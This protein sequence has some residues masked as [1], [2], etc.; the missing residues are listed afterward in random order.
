MNT[1]SQKAELFESFLDGKHDPD[2][3]IYGDI[4]ADEMRPWRNEDFEGYEVWDYFA[5]DYAGYLDYE[6]CIMAT[7]RYIS[8]KILRY[9]AAGDNAAAA[10]ARETMEAL[11]KLAAEGDKVQSGYLPK[12][13]GGL[14]K[15]SL[16]T[17]ISTDQY[18][19]AVFAMWRFI[20]AFPQSPLHQEVANEIVKI[21][22]YFVRNDFT[23]QGYSAVYSTIEERDDLEYPAFVSIHTFGLYLPLMQ[24]AYELTGD[25]KYEQQ[26]Q[27]LFKL[28]FEYDAEKEYVKHQNTCNL[29]NIGLYF[30]WK[31]G[32]H[33]E[34]LAAIMEK[35]WQLDSAMLSSDGLAY[36]QPDITDDHHIEPHYDMDSLDPAASL[37]NYRFMAWR[38]N[39]KTAHSCKTAHSGALLQRV[40]F[41]QRR[42]SDIRRILDHYQKPEDFRRYI[43]F[44]GKQLPPE[45]KYHGNTIPL[46][47][48]GAWLEAYY[49]NDV[50]HAIDGF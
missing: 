23:Y 38:S 33:R 25:K 41:D 6:D 34:K 26:L 10:D 47:F 49:L 35:Q 9:L 19:H 29:L 46:Q 43:D 18:E 48:V 40:R 8:V 15:A 3:L 27:R 21:A 1:L 36:A 50:I 45:Y 5:D 11:L 13:H 44:D 31:R 12:P 32:L 30:C 28:L 2:G 7:G 22:E 20:T 16:S 14:S 24:M 4:K 17:N 42:V 37:I 39:R